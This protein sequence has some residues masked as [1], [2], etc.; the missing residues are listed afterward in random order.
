[1][2]RRMKAT[3][4]A[5][6]LGFAIIGASPA[7]AQ[8]TS[9]VPELEE[10][11]APYLRSIS[12]LHATRDTQLAGITK[13]YVASLERL[14]KEL[15]AHGDLEGGLQVKAE[16]DRVAAGKVP[17]V[18]ERKPMP[19]PLV[20]LRH[21]FENQCSPI[22]T[23]SRQREDQQTKAYLL[24]LDS[25]QQRLTRDNKMDKALLVKAERAK[26]VAPPPVEIVEQ[27]KHGLEKR[28]EKTSWKTDSNSW[29]QKLTFEKG[30]VVVNPDKD[31]KG[32]TEPFKTLDGATVEIPWDGGGK[33]TLIFQLDFSSCDW[34]TIKYRKQ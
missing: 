34:G 20:V 7:F 17:T 16:L 33:I 31:G 1:M 5:L 6:L 9:A 32:R 18:A 25:L 11:R 27:T 4:A 28:L 26:E 8:D 3:H 10:V 30:K 13:S 21:Q 29:L 19:A 23:Y 12:E 22:L 15:T 14:Q 24:A 2:L